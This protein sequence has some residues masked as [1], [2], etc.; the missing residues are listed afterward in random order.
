MIMI[1]N[2]TMNRSVSQTQQVYQPTNNFSIQGYA[3]H[4]FDLFLKI[5]I[6]KSKFS[7]ILS[8]FSNLIGKIEINT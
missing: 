6:L 2:D 4:L 8:C 5:E 3:T 1:R 7:E